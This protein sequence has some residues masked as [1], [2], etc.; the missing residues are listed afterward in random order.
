MLLKTSVVKCD[1]IRINSKTQNLVYSDSGHPYVNVRK[2]IGIIKI[3]SK[4]SRSQFKTIKN[5]L[6]IFNKIAYWNNNFNNNLKKILL[7]EFDPE[8]YENLILQIK[9]C[10]CVPVLVNFRKPAISSMASLNSLKRTQSVIFNPKMLK[11]NDRQAKIAFCIFKVYWV[12]FMR[13][14]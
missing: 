6:Q 3:N 2:K 5:F 7:L 12:N 4:I 14:G 9:K 11:I 10:G 13:H 8:L 1:V